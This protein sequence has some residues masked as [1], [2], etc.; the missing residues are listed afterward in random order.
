M[1]V[2][3]HIVVEDSADDLRDAAATD[4]ELRAHL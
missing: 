1:I 3:Q 4:C 2:T